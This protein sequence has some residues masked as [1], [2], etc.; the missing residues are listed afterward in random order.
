NPS[1]LKDLLAKIQNPTLKK[2]LEEYAALSINYA[3]ELDF[4]KSI[5]RYSENWKNPRWALD[6]PE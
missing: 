6:I 5:G 1:K 4:V 2:A 3:A